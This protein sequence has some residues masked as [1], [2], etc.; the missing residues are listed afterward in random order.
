VVILNYKHETNDNIFI[1]VGKVYSNI[2][3]TSNIAICNI[4]HN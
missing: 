1:R 2:N 3:T 4:N